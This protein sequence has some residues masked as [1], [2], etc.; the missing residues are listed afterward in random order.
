MPPWQPPPR[1][2]SGDRRVQAPTACGAAVG[3]LAPCPAPMPPQAGGTHTAWLLAPASRGPVPWHRTVTSPRG[4][5]LRAVP[6]AQPQPRAAA[7]AGCE[8]CPVG[9]RTR[10]HPVPLQPRSSLP[11]RALLP[12]QGPAAPAVLL[13]AAAAPRA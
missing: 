6:P 3:V 2:G 1:G 12:W 5:G 9:S 4:Q 10:S 7:P 13:S 11:R 8:R